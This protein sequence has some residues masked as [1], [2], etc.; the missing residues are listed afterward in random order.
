MVIFDTV[1][2]VVIIG[3]EWSALQGAAAGSAAETFG[4]ET[5]A[6]R[7]QDAVSDPFPTEGTHSQRFHVAVLTLRRPVV[8]VELHAL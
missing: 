2:V 4:M 5:L 3:D 6:H 1:G 8:V 7:L